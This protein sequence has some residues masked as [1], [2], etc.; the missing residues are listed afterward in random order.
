MTDA[1][2]RSQ[3]RS[4]VVQG[5]AAAVACLLQAG[6]LGEAEDLIDHV[7]ENLGIELYHLLPDE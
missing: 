1:I 3:V 5:I 7:D 2:T 6:M 4:C